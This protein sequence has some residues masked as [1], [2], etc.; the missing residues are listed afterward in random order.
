VLRVVI[1]ARSVVARRS[2]IGNYVEALVRAMVPLA[3]DMRFLLLRHP[4]ER[5][6]IVTHDRVRE[7]AYPGETKSVHTVFGLGLLRGGFRGFDVYHAPA[8]LLPLGLSCPAV[9]TLHDLMW[10]E[11]PR[12]ASA[13][14]PVRLA[15]GIWYRTNIGRAVRRARAIVA[16]SQATATAIARVYPEA[17]AK[18]HVIH[19][20]I[21]EA[22]YG[23]HDDGDAAR[24]ARFVGP[25]RRYSLIVG[26]GSPYKNQ[27]AMVSAFLEATRQTPDHVLVLVRRFSRVDGA[28][29][30]LLAT[31][32][33]RA[34]VIA[35]PYVADDDLAALYRGARMLL[36]ASL[37]EGFGFP[38]LEA[39]AYG[40]PVLASTA[41]ALV[42]VTGDAA[43]HAR[44]DDH[45]DLVAHM[46]R[47]D[48]D[49]ALR[50]RLVAAG[51]RRLRDFRWSH[52]AEQTLEIYRA[53]TQ[54]KR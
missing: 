34:R 35:V 2:G 30:R 20:G 27:L 9:V 43:L 50:A 4:A 40:T 14:L 26:Q 38:A 51:R 12:L 8:D 48:S 31:P 16:I 29:R 7:L 42:E 18:T 28:M 44:A 41:P 54:A 17:A 37:C 3:P 21:D 46:R 23:G 11:T 6:P 10:V 24:V 1:D 22:R 32:E 15:N 5:V 39:M 47:L 25:T 52:A 33:A 13:F 49:D 36:F 45:L 19:H 53:V